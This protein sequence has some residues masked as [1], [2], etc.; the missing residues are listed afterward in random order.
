M[1]C[2]PSRLHQDVQYAHP[3]L[4][5]SMQ[6]VSRKDFSFALKKNGSFLFFE[7]QHKEVGDRGGWRVAEASK[8]VVRALE[9]CHD[10]FIEVRRCM[11]TVSNPS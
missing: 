4:K 10:M 3:F 11:L 9:R 7:G 2:F 5:N 6:H 8:R 1:G